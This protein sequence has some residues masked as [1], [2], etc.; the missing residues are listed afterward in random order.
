M[1]RPIRVAATLA[2]TGLAVAYLIWKIDI[3]ETADVLAEADP[4]W[5]LLAVAI[6]ILTV[7]PMA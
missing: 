5:F 3:H 1:S 6:M 2:F 4:W 7:V